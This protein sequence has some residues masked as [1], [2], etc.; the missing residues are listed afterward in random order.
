M[1]EQAATPQLL[2]LVHLFYPA[3][4]QLGQFAPLAAS[5]MPELARRLLA[6]QQHMTVTVEAW[7]GV[8]VQVDVLARHETATHYARKILLRRSDSLQVVQFGIMRVNLPLLSSP[9]RA[10]IQKAAAPLGRVLLQHG[11]LTQVELYD[12]WRIL[13]AAE[14]AGWLGAATGEPLFGRTAGIDCDGAR[15]VELLE[16]VASTP[17]AP[18]P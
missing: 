11:V 7:Q 4:E 2:A 1:T 18:P 15:A 8:S 6:H 5:D 12:L 9:V 17:S 16:I 10:A 14:L 3:L 13:P